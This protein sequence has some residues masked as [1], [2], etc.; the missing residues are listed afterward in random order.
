MSDKKITQDRASTEAVM[1]TPIYTS[2][3]SEISGFLSMSGRLHTHAK[4][5][6]DV[7]FWRRVEYT[8]KA[9]VSKDKH[10]R[11]LKRSGELNALIGRSRRFS[12]EA[13]A[14]NH[15]EA[16]IERYNK[17]WKKHGKCMSR[18]PIDRGINGSSQ[19]DYSRK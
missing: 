4:S 6:W 10:G 15:A 8:R 1:S 18:K 11:K 3:V 14:R 19:R 12:T 9:E 16:Q 13:A 5:K 7:M 2:Q 17:Y